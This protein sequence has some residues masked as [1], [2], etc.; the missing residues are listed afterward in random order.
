M[1]VDNQS[2]RRVVRIEVT[3]DTDLDE[4]GNAEIPPVA[5]YSVTDIPGCPQASKAIQT[6]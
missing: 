6:P 2:D 3:S 1:A 4:M 5:R